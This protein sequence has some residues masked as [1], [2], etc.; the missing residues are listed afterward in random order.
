MRTFILKTLAFVSLST[1]LTCSLFEKDDN[2]KEDMLTALLLSVWAYNQAAGCSG[3][4]S[5]FTICIPKGIAE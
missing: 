4:K 2:K 1:L 3:P 5:G